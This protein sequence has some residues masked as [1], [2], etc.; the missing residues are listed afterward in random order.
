VCREPCPLRSSDRASVRAPRDSTAMAQNPGSTSYL[1]SSAARTW[2]TRCCRRRRGQRRRHTRCSRTRWSGTRLVPSRERGV[3]SRRASRTAPRPRSGSHPT[4]CARAF[5]GSAGRQ[6]PGAARPKVRQVLP[7]GVGYV[8]FWTHARGGGRAHA[9]RL[10]AAACRAHMAGEARD[11]FIG[12][13]SVLLPPSRE[14]RHNAQTSWRL[15][16]Q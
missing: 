16:T 4:L 12:E 10:S 8:E 6:V 13:A 9:L 7:R 2:P 5:A 3:A 1:A 14:P 15:L 11:E